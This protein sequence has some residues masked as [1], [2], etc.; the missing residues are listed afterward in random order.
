MTMTHDYIGQ[1][2]RA[3]EAAL[4]DTMAAPHNLP[5]T[6]LWE[7]CSPIQGMVWIKCFGRATGRAAIKP[8]CE[9]LRQSGLGW[10]ALTRA[11]WPDG[12][13]RK[14]LIGKIKYWN[15]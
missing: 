5:A 7:K 12:V 14:M 9:I 4:P 2:L 3:I 11:V 15:R 13:E 8:A 6:V 1:T 10:I